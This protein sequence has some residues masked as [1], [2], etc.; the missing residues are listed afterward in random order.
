MVR[1]CRSGDQ[2]GGQGPLHFA[3]AIDPTNSGIV[4]VS[5]DNNFPNNGGFN[6]VTAFR[7]SGS[8]IT[9]LTDVGTGPVNLSITHISGH[10]KFK[11][12]LDIC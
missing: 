1:A 11:T 10:A 2:S 12:D 6:A 7:V 5:G 8:T 3:I 4:Y 9:N